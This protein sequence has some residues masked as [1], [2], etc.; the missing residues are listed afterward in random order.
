LD[1]EELIFRDTCGTEE[2]YGFVVCYY[3]GA[4]FDGNAIS[5]WEA[6]GVSYGISERVIDILVEV[7]V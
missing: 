5:S 6:L 7:G 4:C 3:Y 2:I 1:G